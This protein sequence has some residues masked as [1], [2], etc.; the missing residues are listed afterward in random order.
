MN[1]SIGG[2]KWRLV[3]WAFVL[4]ILKKDLRVGGF[5]WFGGKIGSVDLSRRDRVR[6]K[7]RISVLEKAMHN[8]AISCTRRSRRTPPP[9]KDG[10]PP[11]RGDDDDHDDDSGFLLP[12]RPSKKSRPPPPARSY[13]L[14]R[15]A[16]PPRG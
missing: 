4:E 1:M 5:G 15:P 9:P 7:A 2:K 6:R 13:C 10:A 16:P 11:P 12:S 14:R 8:I 3:V